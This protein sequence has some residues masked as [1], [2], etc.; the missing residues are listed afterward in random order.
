VAAE[1]RTARTEGHRADGFASIEAGIEAIRRGEIVIV[2]DSP[3]R[4]NEGDF[5]M[6]AEKATPEAINFMASVGRGLICVPM[7]RERLAELEIAPIASQSGDR[8]R[9][10]FHVS[11]DI[12]ARTSTG[13]SAADRSAT[14]M[15]L[16]DP[17]TSA[18]DLVQPGHLF[19]LAYEPGGVLRRA[20]HTEASVDLACLADL[21]PAAVICEI[22]GPDGQMARVPLL[23]E[24]AQRH[25]M[26]IIAIS[27][28]IEYRRTR[29]RLVEPAAESRVPILGRSWRVVSYRDLADDCEHLALVL[30]DVADGGDVLARVHSECLVGDVFG[31]SACDCNRRL[32]S[33][34]RRISA[35]GRGAVVYLRGGSGRGLGLPGEAHREPAVEAA[36]P[37]AAAEDREADERGCRAAIQILADLGIRRL[38]LM[39]NNPAKQAGLE[40]EDMTV[41]ERIPLLEEPPNGNVR[42]LVTGQYCVGQSEASG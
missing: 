12:A 22:A 27:D 36:G 24:I 3:D 4:E 38:R 1:Q 40:G 8:Q 19:P 9:T 16:A 14:A 20:G 42:Y 26:P 13:V 37:G 39:T 25:G 2:V 34:L 35:E 6:A 41:V 33:A 10:A 21:Q 15:A 29:T 17:S 32:R 18:T 7:G 31:A 23:R 30:G 5:V 28:L 11:V